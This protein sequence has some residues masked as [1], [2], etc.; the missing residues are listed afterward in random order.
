MLEELLSQPEVEIRGVVTRQHSSINSDFADLSVVAAARDIP[1]LLACANNQD[2]IAAWIRSRGAEICFCFG[3]SYLLRPS[4]LCAAPRGVIGY[5]PTLLPRNRGRHPIIWSIALG[6]RITG[7]S[8]FL[9][10]EGADSGP[11]LSQA[12]V[13]ISPEDDSGTLYVK[14]IST[15][16]LQLIKIIKGLLDES[17]IGVAQD[18]VLATHWRKRSVYDGCID[19]RMPAEGI[20]NLVRALAPPYLG[21]HVDFR[22]A[23]IKVWK[24]RLGEGAAIDLEPG[25][26]IARDGACIHVKCGTGSIVLVMHDFDFTKS[27]PL[28]Q[29][30]YL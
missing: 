2:E 27:V 20:H 9:M 29:G 11:I 1:V 22:G 19:W 23:S 24:T 28:K 17:L 12:S 6:L 25:Y 21:A 8:F 3:W 18:S 16:R 30:D 4:V 26:V 7:S 13:P 14:L 10:D 15:A 5:H